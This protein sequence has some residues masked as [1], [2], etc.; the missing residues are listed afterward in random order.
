MTISTLTG[1]ERFG[2]SFAAFQLHGITAGF[3]HNLPQFLTASFK[4]T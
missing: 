2:Y 4:S 1:A 3:F